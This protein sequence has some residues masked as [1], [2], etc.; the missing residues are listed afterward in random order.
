MAMN[1]S[2]SLLMDDWFGRKL[3]RIARKA[4]AKRIIE[5]F[6]DSFIA[7]EFSICPTTECRAKLLPADFFLRTAIFGPRVPNT[8]MPYTRDSRGRQS[9][10]PVSPANGG[11]I[12]AA[13]GS[14]R[15]PPMRGFWE[16]LNADVLEGM[17][18][19][20]LDIFGCERKLQP[21]GPRA[22]QEL[23]SGTES[24]VG[25]AS[26]GE[27]SFP[28]GGKQAVTPD[29]PF[30]FLASYS[31]VGSQPQGRAQHLPI[32]T[33]RLQEYAGLKKP[34][35]RCFLVA[36]NPIAASLERITWVKGNGFGGR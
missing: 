28:L 35:Q 5:A 26:P 2:L 18:G 6:A 21:S 8:A 14:F 23:P 11:A 3:P 36:T 32:G 16:Y 33:G 29:Y 1:L 4:A 10:R 17:V 31:R 7:R 15:A 9:S 12:W 19:G 34:W 24:I 20:T 27:V 25:R 30:A 22:L 13:N